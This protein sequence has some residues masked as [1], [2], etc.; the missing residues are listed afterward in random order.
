MLTNFFSLFV[1]FSGTLLQF[2]T[3]IIIARFSESDITAYFFLLLSS[4]WI[5]TYI[6]SYGFPNHIF[7]ITSESKHN[8]NFLVLLKKYI[9]Y[10][11]RIIIPVLCF[12]FLF[13]FFIDF[14]FNYQLTNLSIILSTAIILVM[15]R[16]CSE[17]FKGSNRINAGIF[18]DRTTFPLL[19]FI[20]SIYIAYADSF[21]ISSLNFA[22]II[23]S[24]I[25]FIISYL[26][27]IYF[28]NN[29]SNIIEKIGFDN[30]HLGSQYI[31]EIFEVLINRLPIIILN[32]I[33][34]DPNII[35][36]LSICYTLVSISGTINFALYPVFGR[37]YIKKINSRKFKE[38][39][40]TLYNSQVWSFGLY[41][42]YFSLLYFFGISILEFYGKEFVSFYNYLVLYSFLMILNQ[43]FGVSDY[44]MSLI[45]KDLYSIAF[46]CLSLGTLVIFAKIAYDHDSIEI[47][48]LSIAMSAV[49]KS[50]LSYFY[51]IDIV[52]TIKLLSKS[53]TLIFA[54]TAYFRQTNKKVRVSNNTDIAIE[55]FWR[56]ANH[57]AAFAFQ[58]AQDKRMNIA[59]HFHASA[60]IKMAIRK[61]IPSIIV[62]RN[63]YDSIASALVYEPETNPYYFI[64]YYKIFYESLMKIRHKSVVSD[65][66]ETTKNFDMVID[67]VNKKF[68]TNFN[69]FNNTPQNINLVLNQIKEENKITM[70][71]NLN[72][73]IAIPSS[74]KNIK[75]NEILDM[76]NTEYKKQM[77]E[78]NNLY[79]QFISK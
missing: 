62:V 32:L 67:K 31:I 26:S 6:L 44:L 68:N 64:K 12:I 25:S 69:L 60:Q 10:Y 36:G 24:I 29:G 1:R 20:S 8:T 65:F 70:T 7:I 5:A 14:V 45:R 19:V 39:K 33:F 41:I 15:N 3:G 42:I 30:Q 17:V 57:F 75:K 71:K 48:L 2:L 28:L 72:D 13:S 37:D 35:A 18:F 4:V 9:I 63:P 56:C 53:N 74:E 11:F 61:K 58:E 77:E 55:G 22:F 73:K 47:F 38:A 59:K 27:S 34:V 51:L 16:F 52:S 46:K 49:V 43:F 78:L 40:K 23:S 79:E 54:P 50:S 21:S 66:K 76:L